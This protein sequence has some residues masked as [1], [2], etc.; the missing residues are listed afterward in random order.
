MHLKLSL[1]TQ[2][3]VCLSLS[4]YDSCNVLE[5]TCV[6]RVPMHKISYDHLMTRFILGLP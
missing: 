5:N 6:V 4:M 3:R 2:T 1:L